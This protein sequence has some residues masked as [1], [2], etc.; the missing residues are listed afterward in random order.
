M[1][2]RIFETAF[3]HSA[4]IY[5]QVS[6]RDVA[7]AILLPGKEENVRSRIG[8]I[9]SKAT[10][11][12]DGVDSL[13]TLVTRFFNGADV[14]FPWSLVDRSVCSDFQLSVLDAE[15][16]VP[17]GKT[18]S[19]SELARRAKTKSARAAG[20]ALAKNPFP[21]VVACHRTVRSDRSLGGYGGG[22]EMKKQILSMEGVGFDDQGR[23]LPEFFIG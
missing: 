18:I 6:G 11:I 7:T 15:C 9:A 8:R 2:F 19:Y 10:E 13:V 14:E 23:V 17:R 21:I 1:R 16:T 3:G 20:G 4:V 12:E 5:K 22:L